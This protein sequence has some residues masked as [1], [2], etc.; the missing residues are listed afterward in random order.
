MLHQIN[1][2]YKVNCELSKDQ[3][4]LFNEKLDITNKLYTNI[5]NDQKDYFDRTQSFYKPKEYSVKVKQLIKD[6]NINDEE[7]LILDST[8]DAI[9]KTNQN[10]TGKKDTK[11]S[12]FVYTYSTKSKVSALFMPIGYNFLDLS[13]NKMNL[14]LFRAIEIHDNN[15]DYNKVSTKH[16]YLAK[17]DDGYK[18]I[19]NVAYQKDDKELPVKTTLNTIGV[20]IDLQ[21]QYVTSNGE[22]GELAWNEYDITQKKI[23]TLESALTKLHVGS[24]KYKRL[25]NRIVKLKTRF[26]NVQRELQ[27]KL[28]KN[29]VNKYDYIAVQIDGYTNK[30]DDY[31]KIST[32]TRAVNASSQ[33]IKILKQLAKENGKEFYPIPKEI[34]TSKM[35]SHCGTINYNLKSDDKTFHCKECGLDL[36]RDVNAATNIR[37]IAYKI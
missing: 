21:Y 11:K 13:H 10:L 26:I 23:N 27:Y 3:E 37:K 14:P 22:H 32:R 33:F 1:K 15:R 28:A 4:R 8:C 31:F 19:N 16:A 29:L 6:N 5:I 30:Y 2:A 20:D 35:C 9:K 7:N 24:R 36:D 34:M 25:E 18:I 17:F 12:S